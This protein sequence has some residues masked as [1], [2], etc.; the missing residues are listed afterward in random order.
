MIAVQFSG[1]WLHER[2]KPH[3]ID[4]IL[5]VVCACPQHTF[6]SLSKRIGNYHAKVYDS[7]LDCSCRELGGGDYLPNL[8]NGITVC[9]QEE[10]D[11]DIPILLRTLS[12]M[13]WVS[14]EP[15]L[16]PVGLAYHFPSAHGMRNDQFWIV[17]GCETIGS[18]PGRECKLDWVKSVADQCHAA[19]VAIW[20]KQVSHQDQVIH[21]TEQIADLLG[22]TIEQIRQWPKG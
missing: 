22:T 11:R 21:D 6:L 9:T 16:S 14:L 12:A 19:G 5:E 2:V 8:W 17:V 4:A 10:A 1:D 13:R 20:V 15:L 3:W 18:R 7:T